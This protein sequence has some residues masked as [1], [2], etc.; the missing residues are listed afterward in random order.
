MFNS[1]VYYHLPKTVVKMLYDDVDNI[2]TFM[3]GSERIYTNP[4]ITDYIYSQYLL[5][6][7]V[8]ICDDHIMLFMKG[9][10]NPKNVHIRFVI[11]KDYKIRFNSMNFIDLVSQNTPSN[12]ISKEYW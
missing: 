5:S 7:T 1:E 3:N 12:C 8:N 6:N 10:F 4:R 2:I 11:D 9:K